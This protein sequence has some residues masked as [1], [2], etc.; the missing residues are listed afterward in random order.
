MRANIII[1]CSHLRL[2]CVCVYCKKCVGKDGV[3]KRKPGKWG[4]KFA[5]LGDRQLC[6]FL[7]AFAT[8]KTAVYTM[9]SKLPSMKNGDIINPIKNI[10]FQS[11]NVVLILGVLTTSL[12][13]NFNLYLQLVLMRS[14]FSNMYVNM[15][16][17]VMGLFNMTDT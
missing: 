15:Y 1:Y 11:S 14:K 9:D 13:T 5:L 17:F 3:N 10:K 6:V 8:K 4:N 12:S 16:E 2:I 7:L